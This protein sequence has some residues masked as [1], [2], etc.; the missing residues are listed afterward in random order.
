MGAVKISRPQGHGGA[1]EKLNELYT[2]KPALYEWDDKP[3]GFAWINSINS[4]ENLL[5]FL[6][7]TRKKESLLVV[8]ANF[9]G[10][11]K[12]VKS[13]CRMKAATR[14]F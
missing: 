8:A 9:S 7:K 10:V 14:K 2:T 4:T 13:V 3:E 11:E 1:G 12:Q 5:T 6:R